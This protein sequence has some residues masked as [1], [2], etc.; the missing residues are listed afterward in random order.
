LPAVYSWL[1]ES[2]INNVLQ[3]LAG[4]NNTIDGY[5]TLQQAIG[6]DCRPVIIKEMMPGAF[7][8][9]SVSKISLE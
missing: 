7:S 5:I 8:G 6:L 2:T 4:S 3:L 9:T 1:R